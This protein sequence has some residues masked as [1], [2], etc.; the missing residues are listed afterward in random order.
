MSSATRLSMARSGNNNLSEPSHGGTNVTMFQPAITPPLTGSKVTG[1]QSV[2]PEFFQ[3]L[4]A[5]NS[6]LRDSVRPEY[7]IPPKPADHY[8]LVVIGGGTAGLV[9]AAGAAGL[10]AQ[11]ALIERYALGGDCLNVGCVPSKS[12]LA[13]S[14]AA[15]NARN[16]ATFGVRTGEVE[17]DF[18]KVMARLRRLRADISANDS[19]E[20][21]SKLGVD[22]FFGSARFLNGN[23]IEVGDSVLRFSRAAIAT[24]A[25]AIMLPIPGLAEAGVLTNET[26]FTLTTLPKRFAVIGA[27]PIGCEMAQAFQRF[28]S[29]VTLFK[30][31]GGILPRDDRNASAIVERSLKQDGIDIRS[32]VTIERVERIGDLRRIYLTEDGR[33]D[34]LEFDQILVGVG[35]APNV[36]GLDLEKADVEYDTR[37]G[38]KVDER[39]RTTNPRI[40]GVGDV[41]V[42]YKFTHVADSTARIVI[43]NALFG[44]RKKHTDLV[45]P[46]CTYT[47][48]E[49]A[50]TGMSV[51]EAEKRGFR[52]KTFTQDFSTVD[53]TIL[54][55][56]I[57]GFV[58]VVTNAKNGEILGATIVGPHAGDLIS[59][60]T[61]AIKSGVSLGSLASVIHPYPTIAE[62]IRKTGDQYNRT[63]LTPTIAKLMKTWLRWFR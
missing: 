58:C 54:E 51:T 38:I 26:L 50:H 23:S 20:R 8:N 14:R 27:G 40:F 7:W 42:P 41:C 28:G 17:V 29:Q 37:A 61:L 47:D 63:R 22:V 1:E 39:L 16:A 35:R 53:R 5:D 19:A 52:V 13:A 34:V 3:P 32:S 21:F 10:G 60:L 59:E 55:E 30:S 33:P 44:G 2:L 31:T 6:R 12:L 62:A 36:E 49:L 57:E 48:P 45:V 24:G 46:W 56:Q 9:T 4:D 15:A 43:Q 25:R 11:V 18:P